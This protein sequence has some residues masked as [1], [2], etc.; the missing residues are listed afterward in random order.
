MNGQQAFVYPPSQHPAQIQAHQGQP[1]PGQPGQQAQ[2]P[3]RP[4]SEDQTQNAMLGQAPGVGPNA[5]QPLAGSSDALAAATGAP[6]L[7]LMQE[8]QQQQ[9]QQVVAQEPPSHSMIELGRR[10]T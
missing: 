6:V 10:Y 1:A 8:Q 3:Q 7:P 5:L 4:Q 2:G 9:Q